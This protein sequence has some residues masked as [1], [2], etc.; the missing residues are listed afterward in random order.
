MSLKP[1]PVGPMPE[2]VIMEDISETGPLA[3]TDALQ[4]E[5]SGESSEHFSSIEAFYNSIV[6]YEW[7]RLDHYLLEFA[8][9]KHYL[10]QFLP[11]PPAR[12]CDI[13][14]G[15]GR[16]AIFL[17]QQGYEV[18]LIDLAPAN[19]DWASKQ[20]AQAGLKG[21]FLVGDARDLSEFADNSFDGAL[22]LGPLYHL[23]SLHSRLRCVAEMRRVLR[24]GGIAFSMMLTRAA[25][26]YEG[27][28]RWPEGI[29]NIDGVE[30]LLR[31][32]RDFNFEKIPADFVDNSGLYCATAQEV[33]P[34]HEQH[35]FATHA[36]V[37]CEGIL[38]GRREQLMALEPEVRD[39]WVRLMLQMC[40]D[41]STLGAA[42]RILYVG[43]AV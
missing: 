35:H 20:F 38:G 40:E 43:K 19:I 17:A 3:K 1:E 41:E 23:P 28:N 25:T 22:L 31:T 8:A 27:F 42:E 15:P 39:A 7:K 37:G 36:V 4:S 12:I 32:G 26:F 18:T 9:V 6:M 14:G 2:G 33:R 34:L 11:P 21:E 13:G 30:K 24:R 29:F 5:E 16:Y 10:G